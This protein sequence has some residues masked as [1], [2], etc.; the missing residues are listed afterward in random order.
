DE[1]T[2]GLEAGLVHDLAEGV[3][4]TFKGSVERRR[5]GDIFLALPGLMIGYRKA[6]VAA[7]ASVGLSADHSG[8]RSHITAAISNLNRGAAEFT[9][10]G[11]PR[12]Q[13]EAGYRL[14]T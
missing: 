8:G 1:E 5:D 2:I 4:L 12:T 6:D 9:L 11:L 3:K 10:A 7:A 13:L 14:A